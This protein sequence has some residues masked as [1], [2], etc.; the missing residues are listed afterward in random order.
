M[1][2]GCTR[3]HPGQHDEARFKREVAPKLGA[4]LRSCNAR[5][6]QCREA[7][8]CSAGGAAVGQWWGCG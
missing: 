3:E 2:L 8:R 1:Q 5:E 7:P 4:M 6:A